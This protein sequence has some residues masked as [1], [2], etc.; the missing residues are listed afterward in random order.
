MKC[1]IIATTIAIAIGQVAMT[2]VSADEIL[3]PY[4]VRSP[5]ITTVVPSN[6]GLKAMGNKALSRK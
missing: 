5:T 1:L 6:K 3:F 4:I 2:P